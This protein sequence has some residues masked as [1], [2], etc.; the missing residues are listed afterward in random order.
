[1]EYLAV[2]EVARLFGVDPS[3]V[4]RWERDG[5]FKARRTFGGQRRYSRVDIEA[6]IAQ[7]EREAS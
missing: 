4:R 1:P 5:R 7:M 2:G 6:A 3:T